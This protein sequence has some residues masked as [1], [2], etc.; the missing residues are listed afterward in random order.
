MHAALMKKRGQ[1]TEQSA[2]LLAEK[3][4]LDMD[5]LRKDMKSDEVSKIITSTRE[6]GNKLGI[7]GTP[8]Y[9]IGD[10]S[11]PGAPEDLFKA[12]QQ[13][14]ADVRLNGCETSC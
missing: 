13:K 5:K 7:Q 3:M 9:L 10:R 6:I 4:G 1:S 8:F 11:I 2:L 12:F 14:V